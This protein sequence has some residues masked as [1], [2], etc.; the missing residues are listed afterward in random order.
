MKEVEAVEVEE[1]GEEACWLWVQLAA[2][3]F[4]ICVCFGLTS[5]LAAANTLIWL[6]FYFSWWG[7]WKLSGG[8]VGKERPRPGRQEVESR[9][10]WLDCCWEIMKKKPK[11]QDLFWKTRWG[12]CFPEHFWMLYAKNNHFWTWGEWIPVK[13]WGSLWIFRN[14]ENH[15]C[16]V[17]VLET[18]GA[19]D[20]EVWRSDLLHFCATTRA[21]TT[22]HNNSIQNNNTVVFMFAMFWAIKFDFHF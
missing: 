8:A 4:L 5:Q 12:Q 9:Q 11:H 20:L 10:K 22:R 16:V 19:G 1:E 3:V 6:S 17:V 18:W 15:Q 2:H 13:Y 21:T 7:E 14:L